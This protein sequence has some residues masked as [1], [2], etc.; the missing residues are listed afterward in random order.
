MPHATLKLLPG[1][2]ENRT[3]ALNEAGISISQLV[4]FVPDKQGIGLVQKLGGWSKYPGVGTNATAT[5]PSITRAL[6]AWEDVNSTTHLAIGNQASSTTGDALSVI[7][8]SLN[9]STAQ[10]VVITPRTYQSNPQPL[11]SASTTSGSNVVTIYDPGSN[12][13]SFDVVFIKVPILI[14]GLVVFGEYQCT[15]IDTDH[16]SVSVTDING[17]AVLANATVTNGGTSPEFFFNPGEAFVNVYMPGNNYAPGDLFPILV[18]FNLGSITLSGGYNVY[19]ADPPNP[20]Y[21]RIFASAA[22]TSA[23]TTATS[24]TGSTATV[25]FSGT[26]AIQPG[27]TVLIYGVTPV[28]YNGEYTVTSYT[29]NS[30][31]YASSTTGSQSVSGYVFA[32]SGYLNN[33][34]AS[35]QYFINPSPAIATVGYG[36]GGYGAGGYGVGGVA[37]FTPN[38]GSAISAV[39]WTLDNWGSDLIACSV[40]GQLFSWSPNSSSAVANLILNAPFV[41]DGA[42]VAMPQRQVIAWGS[43][44]E[45]VQDPLLIRWSD[46]EDYNSWTATLV[47]QAGSYRLP[48]G[49]RIVGC[50]QGPQQGLVWTDLAIWAM[51]Y[52]GPPYVYQFNEVG[53][54]C[55]LVGRK[56][57]ASLNGIIYWM[58]Q[59]Q[60]YRLGGS[61]VEV[62]RCPIWDVIFQDIDFSNSS[63]IRV[64]PNS[65]FG[66]ISWYYPTTTS[67]GEI[68]KYVKYNVNLDIWDY[69]SL[70][71]T[72][73]VN[74]SVL[75]PP[76]GSNGNYIFQHETSK[77]A[78][79]PITG[80]PV[81]MNSYF[82]TGYS[83]IS[84]AEWKIFVDQVW[85]DM[86]WGY[87]NGSQ[88]ATVLLTFYVADYPGSAVSA[89]SGGVRTYG[90]YTM[91]DATTFLTPR[92]RGRLLSVKIES[93]DLGSFW[94]IGAMRYR[95]SQ[96]GKF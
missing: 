13:S 29:S 18:P 83:V 11:I 5:A 34:Y 57:A 63:K 45:G 77:D 23:P 25:S 32:L 67:G 61:G 50:I 78:A 17:N 58:S 72:A 62:V 70:V 33:K 65:A 42:F 60:F 49:S 56:A 46:V 54:G 15:S 85:P 80:A 4:R 47:N 96:D 71:R 55:G 35:Y 52:V 26:Y 3:L 27:S 7:N 88:T 64:A 44:F 79:D 53:V 48:K 93:N 21:F 75:G 9:S 10:P 92:F 81:A 1:V 87:F 14:A 22:A 30:V 51:Q 28:G 8:N 76:I 2:D 12:I 41:N 40:G 59:N 73:W 43:T 37:T 16:Y 6:W 68:S 82:Q 74:Q 91:T 19:A 31:S 86:K 95:F 66:E 94:R 24:G 84:E 36:V 89:A 69:G 38:T 20:D 39:D 90:P